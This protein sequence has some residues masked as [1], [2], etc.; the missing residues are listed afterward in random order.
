[1]LTAWVPGPPG[2]A[3]IETLPLASVQPQGGL[4]GLS[5][6]LDPGS[7]AKHTRSPATGFVPSWMFAVT[8][9]DA[10]DGIAP[11]SAVS[12]VVYPASVAGSITRSVAEP[13]SPPPNRSQ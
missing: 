9:E 13:A 3:V 8:V 2:V 11:G 1:A 5:W 12:V 4:H 10:P 7:Q 6:P